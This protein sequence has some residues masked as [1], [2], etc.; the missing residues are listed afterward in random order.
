MTL[1]QTIHSD[2]LIQHFISISIERHTKEMFVS[3]LPTSGLFHI[4]LRLLISSA[5]K[6]PSFVQPQIIICAAIVI[7]PIVIARTPL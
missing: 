1:Q 2:E 3:G 7:H 5:R 6:H 4:Y